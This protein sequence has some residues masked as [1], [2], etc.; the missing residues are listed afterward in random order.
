MCGGYFESIF[1]IVNILLE[2]SKFTRLIQSHRGFDAF[3]YDCCVDWAIELLQKG[4]ITDNVEMLASFSKPVNYWEIKH[5]VG[6]VLKDFNL[7]E[8]E[9]KKALASKAYF[10]I[11]SILNNEGIILHHLRTLCQMCIDDDYEESIYPFYL[12]KYSWEDLEDLGMSCHYPNVTFN[13]FFE[14]VL[15]EANVWMKNF[16]ELK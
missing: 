15:N 10:Y 12:L 11:W 4:I 14:T 8:F 7:E 16:E 5:Y 6:N 9:G 13:N 3:R 2:K 1:S